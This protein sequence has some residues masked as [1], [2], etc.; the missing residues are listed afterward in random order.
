M[1]WCPAPSGPSRRTRRSLEYGSVIAK[2]ERM[3]NSDRLE[4]RG[5]RRMVRSGRLLL[6]IG[7]IGLAVLGLTH[8]DFVPKWQPVPAGLPFRKFFA[9]TSNLLILAC[10]AGLLLPRV[11]EVSALALGLFLMSWTFILHGPLVLAHPTSMG[12]WGYACGTVAVGTGTLTLWTIVS[13][14]HRAASERALPSRIRIILRA[15][16]ALSLVE[17]G[18]GHLLYARGLSSLVPTWLPWRTA[19]VYFTGCCHI[20]AGLALLFNVLSGMAASLEAAMMSSFV[21]LVDIPHS[22]LIR[23]RQPLTALCFETALVGSVWIVAGSLSDL[24]EFRWREHPNQYAGGSPP[25]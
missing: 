21:L 2:Q 16:L 15:L 1:Q 20:A 25:V 17:Y 23:T 10:G 9:Y 4:T 7:I 5:S 11:E 19:I 22:V 3:V 6:A 18:V 12:L 24:N 14:R 13:E 8:A